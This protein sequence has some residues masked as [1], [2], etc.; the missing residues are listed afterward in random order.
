MA[1]RECDT[2]SGFCLTS[3]PARVTVSFTIAVP[4]CTVVVS[5]V[6][7]P[8]PADAQGAGVP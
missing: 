2:V 8:G 6:L 7:S 1:E 5:L 3:P 4:R